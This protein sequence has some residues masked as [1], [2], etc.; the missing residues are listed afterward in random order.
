MFTKGYM[1]L[2]YNFGG[3]LENRFAVNLGLFCAAE[4]DG[5]DE[6]SQLGHRLLTSP[7]S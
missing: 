3:K 2:F 5:L 6:N 1:N 7:S 4:T